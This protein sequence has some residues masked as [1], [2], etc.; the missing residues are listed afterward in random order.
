MGEVLSINI[1]SEKGTEKN[2][3]QRAIAVEDWGIKGDAHAG[4]WSRQVS[5][6][7]VEALEKVPDDKREEVL[8]GGY[9]ENI[10]INGVDLN[11]LSVGSLWQIGEAVIRIMHIGKDEFKEQGRPYIVSREGRFG[12]VVKGGQIKIGD[13]VVVLSQK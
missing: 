10:T 9:T 2:S 1:S 11:E 7:P 6:F 5:I 8:A 3:I 13:D 4:H 12:E